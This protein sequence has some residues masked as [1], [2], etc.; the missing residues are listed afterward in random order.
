M[1]LASLRAGMMMDTVGEDCT[2]SSALSAG[3]RRAR[4]A[5]RETS[6]TMTL[7]RRRAKMEKS[8]RANSATKV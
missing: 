4:W 2:G 3:T 6:K 7:P 5:S 1:L 8:I